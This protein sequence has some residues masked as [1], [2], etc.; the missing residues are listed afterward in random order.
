[1]V[2][3]W[4][5]ARI[6]RKSG[7]RSADGPDVNPSVHHEHWLVHRTDAGDQRHRLECPGTVRIGRAVGS[8]VLLAHPSVSREHAVLE[9]TPDARSG[10]SWRITDRGSAS[11]TRVNGV[12]L[13]AHRSLVLEPGDRVSIGP[14]QFDYL[15]R[16]TADASPVS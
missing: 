13:Q 5:N 4:P 1:M 6:R 15:R 16:V 10:G 9:W 8:D 11:G 3:P 14:L 2:A 12:A 7:F